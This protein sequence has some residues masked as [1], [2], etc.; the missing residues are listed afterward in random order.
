MNTIIK[1]YLNLYLSFFYNMVKYTCTGRN[2][3]NHCKQIGK[4]ENLTFQIIEYNKYEGN[5]NKVDN[6]NNVKYPNTSYIC[7]LDCEGRTFICAN[8]SKRAS[9]DSVFNSAD[10]YIRS[11]L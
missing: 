9:I 7:T 8:S 10:S 3:Y 1:I 2:L 11:F 5:T 6:Y 4:P